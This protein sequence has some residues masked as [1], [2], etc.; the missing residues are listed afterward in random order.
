MNIKNI[1]IFHLVFLTLPIAGV[2]VPMIGTLKLSIFT[3]ILICILR[4]RRTISIKNLKIIALFLA[5]YSF[6]ALWTIDTQSSLVGV[7]GVLQLYI[8]IYSFI[9]ILSEDDIDATSIIKNAIYISV[10]LHLTYYLMGVIYYNGG[11]EDNEKLLGIMIDRGMMRAKGVTDDPNILSLYMGFACIY[12]AFLTSKLDFFRKFFLIL[13]VLL[14]VLTLSRGGILAIS[15]AILT[16]YL[17]NIVRDPKKIVK[18]MLLLFVISF[19]IYFILSEYTIVSEIINKRIESASTGSGRFY[20]WDFAFEKI[21]QS[22]IFGY[23]IFT[24]KYIF[25]ELLG[26]VGYSHNT[27]IDITLESGLI[28]LFIFSC[29][30]L[31]I[32]YIANLKFNNYPWMMISLFFILIQFM[33]L[34]LSF[35]EF[36]YFF[37]VVVMVLNYRER[38]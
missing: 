7:L 6:T 26:K 19:P 11:Y 12:L 29:M 31:S 17:K 4:F 14:F 23:G 10:T 36:F 9:I 13:A 20:L 25:I 37:C 33:S 8:Y 5:Y 2:K 38:V 28:G 16:Y 22:P 1:Y 32:L 18:L 15:L 24:T 35:N 34:S 30:I 27:Y 21:E 3:A